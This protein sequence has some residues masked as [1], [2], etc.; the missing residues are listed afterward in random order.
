MLQQMRKG[1]GNL[2]AKLVLVL[3]VLSFV[4]WG[5]G[6][7]L[8][9]IALGGRNE[10]DVAKV[11]GEAITLNAL[12]RQYQIDLQQNQLASLGKDVLKAMRLADLSLD[13]LINQ[14]IWDAEAKKIGLEVSDNMIQQA[15][16]ADPN[17]H[18]SKGSFSKDIFMGT[19]RN[20]RIGEVEY[21]NQV[22]R[23]LL[24]QQ[25]DAALASDNAAPS[26]LTDAVFSWIGERRSGR[27]FTLAASGAEL[28]TLRSQINEA[29]LQSYYNEHK[30]EYRQETLRQVEFLWVDVKALASTI[31]ITDEAVRQEYESSK[32]ALASPEKRELLQL[33][34]P[35][36]AN[37]AEWQAKLGQL[38]LPLTAEQ[39]EAKLTGAKVTELGLLTKEDFPD[40]NLADNAFSV[41]GVGVSQISQGPFGD[42]AF[43]TT[44]IIAVK[45]PDL[46]SLQ[47]SIKD[48]LAQ[49][50]AKL[51]A[52]KLIA[53]LDEGSGKGK[54]LEELAKELQLTLHKVTIGRD[55][56]DAKGESLTLPAGKFLESLFEQGIGETGFVNETGDGGAFLAKVVAETASRLLDYD[57]VKGKLRNEL[58]KD[59]LQKSLAQRA[60]QFVEKAKSNKDLAGL[61]NEAKAKLQSF[62]PIDRQA[63]VAVDKT[64]LNVTPPALPAE[65]D[66]E[67]AD[68]L[69][70]IP[71]VGGVTSFERPPNLDAKTKGNGDNEGDDNAQAASIG[72]MV[73]VELDAIESANPQKD[74]EMKKRLGEAVSR[75]LAT[76]LQAELLAGWQRKFDVKR[77]PDV[78]D[79]L[80]GA[81]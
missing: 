74:A 80:Y 14:A 6:S 30:E 42:V 5:I 73:L 43:I 79:R 15:I 46:A 26:A 45:I 31:S 2:L 67:F 44:K 39:I 64:K 24:Q 63:L 51:E 1:A 52:N 75:I 62:P 56:R 76:D 71:A 34:L 32:N 13:R 49:K 70:T 27:F 54:K 3:L 40:A 61:A 60:A 20:M 78:V 12:A 37:R 58:A 72:T 21:I 8:Q 22:R 57:E 28:A 68:N 4:G 25:I 19:L 18:D 55:G 23:R 9:N 17:F 10:N 41:K 7:Y 48:R 29:D 81:E 11:N 36:G 66:R 69:F 47:A 16:A 33:L 77:Y 53:S 38:T 50:Q 65:I 35:N 59:R